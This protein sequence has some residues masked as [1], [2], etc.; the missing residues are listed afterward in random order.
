ML[1]LPYLSKI[2]RLG[3]RDGCKQTTKNSNRFAGALQMLAE[4]IEFTLDQSR[5]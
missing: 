2:K 3:A 1:G 5:R 4:N